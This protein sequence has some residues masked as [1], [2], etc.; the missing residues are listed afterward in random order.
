VCHHPAQTLHS[1]KEKQEVGI[2]NP[3]GAEAQL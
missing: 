2:Q 3:P 1:R